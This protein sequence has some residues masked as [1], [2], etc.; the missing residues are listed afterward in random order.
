MKKLFCIVCAALSLCLLAGCQ[1]PNSVQ[2]DLYQGYGENLKLIHLNAS[3][4]EKRERMEAFLEVIQNA[5]P[6][7]KELS[8]F[9]YYPD[10]KLELE[11]AEGFADAITAIVDVNG[12]YI[13]F[14]YPGPYPERSGAIY[15]SHTTAEEFKELVHQA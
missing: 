15:R 10:Y 8:M 4:G 12:E 2:M 7:D 3:S 9:A 5:E 6:L 13:D 14:Y 1:N 11:G